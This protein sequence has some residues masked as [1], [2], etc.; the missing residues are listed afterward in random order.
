LDNDNLCNYIKLGDYVDVTKKNINNTALS[1]VVRVALL[2]TY[3]GLWVDATTFCNKPLN[4]WIKDYIDQDFFAFSK[5]G[6]D[7]LLS[8]WFIYSTKEHYIISQWLKSIIGYYEINHTPHTYFWVHYL[9]GD[10]YHQD[11]KFMNIWDNVPKICAD[12]P[13]HLLHTGMFKTMTGQIK[14][15]IDEQVT[16]VY[17]LTY[18][19]EFPL[20]DKTLIVYYLYSTIFETKE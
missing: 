4:E 10:L 9:F 1:D 6:Q 12:A 19:H 7:R 17:K 13:H 2:K 15:E 16:P 20:Y 3:G 11:I 8:T 18:K 14:K 5:P